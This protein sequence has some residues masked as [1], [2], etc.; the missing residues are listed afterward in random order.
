MASRSRPVPSRRAVSA[1]TG[2]VKNTHACAPTPDRDTSSATGTCS[3]R[4]ALT[5]ISAS[6]NASGPS[7]SAASHQHRSPSSSGYSPM[8]TSPFRCAAS[9]PGVS[10]RK[11]ASSCLMPLR[12]PPRTA[13]T[14]PPLPVRGLSY[15]IAYTSVREANSAPKNATFASGGDLS[16]TSPGGASKNRPA[17]DQ[18]EPPAAGSSSAAG[19]A[20]RSPPAAVPAQ[21]QPPPGSQPRG[22]A[23]RQQ[24]QAGHPR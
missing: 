5:Y 17:Q 15:R 10:G 14:Q 2:E 16:S 19:A 21:L 20:G 8:C 22:H 11:S 1:E 9:T 12:Q 4:A 7:K 24:P 6:T 13:G 3:A 18:A 23:I